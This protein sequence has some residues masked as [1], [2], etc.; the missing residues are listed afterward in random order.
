MFRTQ[1]STKHYHS[2]CTQKLPVKFKKLK[3]KNPAAPLIEKLLCL[4]AQFNFLI[5][6]IC[7]NDSGAC[8]V[9]FFFLRSSVEVIDNSKFARAN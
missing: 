3:P 4:I 5:A 1:L 8:F 7:L 2:I 6:L 9:L